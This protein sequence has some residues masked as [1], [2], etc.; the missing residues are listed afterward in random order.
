MFSK[1]FGS[2]KKENGFTILDLKENEERLDDAFKTNRDLHEGL[3]E[4]GFSLAVARIE[5]IQ[6][7]KAC[8]QRLGGSP[9]M[10]MKEPWESQFKLMNHLAWQRMPKEQFD[11]VLIAAASA[12]FNSNPI[13]NAQAQTIGYW[14]L[15]CPVLASDHFIALPG[16][17]TG[18]ENRKFVVSHDRFFEKIESKA[19]GLPVSRWMKKLLDQFGEDLRIEKMEKSNSSFDGLF[20]S[21]FEETAGD[22]GRPL[23][24]AEK[25]AIA[26]AVLYALKAVP[27]FPYYAVPNV[28]GRASSI[29]A[30]RVLTHWHEE[31]GLHHLREDLGHTQD[32]MERNLMAAIRKENSPEWQSSSAR[33]V[34]IGTR[35]VLYALV[36]TGGE[37]FSRAQSLYD[38]LSKTYFQMVDDEAIQ[39]ETKKLFAGMVKDEQDKEDFGMIL[40]HS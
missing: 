1:L 36:G 18:P 32:D 22:L 28:M 40:S 19:G 30:F 35:C 26:C 39:I 9:C 25:A 12:L 7:E 31:Y 4:L 5:L 37:G 20:Q 2:K 34:I 13:T 16:L 8:V 33:G 14:S 17:S 11:E 27:S 3:E 6:N 23:K 10:Y 38:T 21:G 24:N 15:L 29:L